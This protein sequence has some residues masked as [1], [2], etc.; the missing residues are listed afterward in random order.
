MKNARFSYSIINFCKV[1]LYYLPNL[2]QNQST[3]G[4]IGA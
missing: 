2:N 1:L 3:F 4:N